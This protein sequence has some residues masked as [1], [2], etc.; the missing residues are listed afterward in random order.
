[1]YYPTMRRRPVSR[2]A[3][4]ACLSHT[5]A[6][7]S[8]KFLLSA[9]LL[10]ALWRTPAALAESVVFHDA[11]ADPALGLDY[12]RT[13]SAIDAIYQGFISAGIM[14]GA[15][16][17]D[18]PS[19]WRGAPGVAIL[20]FDGDGDLDIYVANGPGSANS[21]FSNQLRET[22]YL[23]FLDV[24]ASA[25]VAATAQDSS[26]VC[27]GDT[28]ND[29]DRDLLVLSDFGPNLFF[30]NLGDGTF[31]DLSLASGLG[32][33]DRDSASC[34]FGDVDGDGLL[35]VAIGNT[36]DWSS[37][38]AIG[39]EPF[40]A[41][42]HNQLFLNRGG[43]L[44]IDVS[45][46]SGLTATAGFSPP[47]FD[48][49]PTISWAIAMVDYDQDGDVDIV[50]ADDQAGIPEAA[51]SGVDRGLLHIF[52]NDGSG[53]FT[54]VSAV[55]Q[56]NLPGCWMGL[57]FADLN[58]DGTI[59]I[60]GTNCG[61]YGRTLFSTINP[62]YGAFSPFVLG[63]RASRWLL[64]QSDRSF[65]DPGVG[66]LVA[67]PFGWGTSMA[68]YD[69]DGDT[70]IFYY[71]D[72]AFGP[73]VSH[74]NPGAV[75]TNDGA[76]N[77]SRDAVALAGSANHSRRHVQGV[78][79]GDLDDDGFSDVVS[80]SS[81]DVQDAI[82]L[83]A[84]GFSHGSPFD[85]SGFYQANFVPT[86][87]LGVW[88]AAGLPDN[89]DGSLAVEIS[90][91]NSNRWVKIRTQ[92]SVGLTAGGRVNR[93]GIGAVV[94]FRPRYGKPA[95]QPV[96]G[97]SSYSS[98]DSLEIGFGLGSAYRGTVDILW[99][100]GVR[101]RLY[102]VWYGERLL[103]PEIP[104]SIDDPSLTFFAYLIQ[105]SQALD[106]LEDAGVVDHAQGTR[107]FFSALLAFLEERAG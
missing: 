78:A 107:F 12:E 51:A 82:P 20:D 85:V 56:S 71:G 80:A 67:V 6:T 103:F 58:H 21:L 38:I 2:A 18:V 25:G 62:V 43:N 29:G 40:A 53:N 49:N 79:I 65:T 48:G 15:D 100:G 61:A 8:T 9:L 3:D 60:F 87:V 96:L 1:M 93:D 102:G 69:N 72:L 39:L 19:K 31:Q 84:V 89:V 46:S 33:D 22:G 24:A 34:S 77:F 54:D 92:G 76:A 70:D 35:D 41:N 81:H 105:V 11:A 36:F 99:P 101:N 45:V 97:G 27:F 4:S 91:G 30:E 64:Q 7:L 16:L 52:D 47:G 10:T 95:T 57:S 98:Q 73:L 106:E 104:V 90:S 68:D 32:S 5:S 66:S 55:R 88:A 42:D 13:R 59:D 86:S 23:S 37:N 26:G 74:E 28:D 50:H 83:T 17:F 14:T 44:F 63:A 94:S 75:L